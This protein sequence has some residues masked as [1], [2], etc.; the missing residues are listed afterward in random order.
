MQFMFFSCRYI[1]GML[2]NCYF[3]ESRLKYYFKQE[4]NV[5]VSIIYDFYLF[6]YFRYLGYGLHKYTYHLYLCLHL[7]LYI[8]LYTFKGNY[9]TQK[10]YFYQQIKTNKL[11]LLQNITS[12]AK[13]DPKNKSTKVIETHSPTYRL[14]DLIKMYKF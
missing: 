14:R 8:P 12:T 13:Y 4:S 3:R 5:L 2:S 10:N 1:L 6:V 7:Y 11:K 9:T